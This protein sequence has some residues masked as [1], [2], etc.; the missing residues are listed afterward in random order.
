LVIF[1]YTDPPGAEILP[2]ERSADAERA[3]LRNNAAI[4]GKAFWK[5]NGAC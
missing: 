5:R 1:G 4:E 2:A 3:P